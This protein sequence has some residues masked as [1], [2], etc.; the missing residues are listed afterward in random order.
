MRLVAVVFCRLLLTL[1]QPKRLLFRPH[2]LR[3][4]AGV[5]DR[6]ALAP[7][8]RGLQRPGPP[9][10]PLLPLLAPC[11]V[12]KPIYRLPPPLVI[13]LQAQT[14]FSKFLQVLLRIHLQGFSP[15]SLGEVI[16]RRLR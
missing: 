2:Q 16:L 3:R 7:V 14:A 9:L 10:L 4:L 8:L 13:T 1:R 5:L 12:L 11:K 15:A 6:A